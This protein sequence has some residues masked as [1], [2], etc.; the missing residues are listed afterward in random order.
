MRRVPSSGAG[1]DFDLTAG[2]GASLADRR[3]FLTRQG[4][5]G[6]AHTLDALHGLLAFVRFQ[7]ALYSF[8][9]PS[10]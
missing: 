3:L 5:V 9:R 2:T 6:E 7:T 1:H 4:N 8:S 10:Q